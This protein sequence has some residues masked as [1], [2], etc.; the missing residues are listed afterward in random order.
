MSWTYDGNENEAYG[1][2]YPGYKRVDGAFLK[3]VC[4]PDAEKEAEESK[5]FWEIYVE[6]DEPK[7]EKEKE[8]VEHVFYKKEYYLESYKTKENYIKSNT[9]LV[10][11]AVVTKD[12]KWHEKGQMGWFGIG[13]NEDHIGWPDTF[14]KLVWGN[15]EDGDYITVVDCH[16]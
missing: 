3:D 11:Y 7:N 15:V 4:F 12:G 6:G 2:D 14:K 10:L 5:R 16:I 9:G 13:S 1:C 8:L